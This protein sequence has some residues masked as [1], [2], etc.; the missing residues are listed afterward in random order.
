[1]EGRGGGGRVQ[2]LIGDEPWILTQMPAAIRLFYLMRAVLL[3]DIH[4]SVNNH[5]HDCHLILARGVKQTFTTTWPYASLFSEVA[6]TISYALSMQDAE[7]GWFT[8][9]SPIGV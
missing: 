1:M 4:S 2:W 8:L 6:S 7:F 9:H 3:S 5:T